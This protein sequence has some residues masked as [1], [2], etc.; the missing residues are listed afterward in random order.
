[1]VFK[2]SEIAEEIDEIK[3]E[4]VDVY[5]STDNSDLAKELKEKMNGLDSSDQI[6]MVF[7]GQ[8]TAGKSSIISALTS[9]GSIKIDSD[10]STDRVTDYPWNGLTLTDTPGLYTENPEHNALAVESIKNA[11]LLVYCITSDLF[12]PYTI[13]D[14]KKWAFR[15]GYSGKMFL[16]INKMSK[17]SGKY[18]E[19]VENYSETLNNSLSPYSLKDVTHSFVDAV[20]YKKGVKASDI[21]LI[22]YSHFEDFIKQLNQFVKDKGELG[23]LDTPIQ[24]MKDSIDQMII[25][26]S[27]DD[28]QIAYSKTLSRIE[29][30]VE[31]QRNQVNIEANNIVRRGLQPIVDRGYELSK[32]I[33][34]K[35]LKPEDNNVNEL[36]SECCEKINKELAKVCEESVARLNE[37]IEQVLQSETAQY[38]FNSICKT[39]E[40]KKRLFEKKEK[41]VTRIQFEQIDSIVKKV[42]GKV[43]N[44]VPIEEGTRKLFISASDVAGSN[45]HLMIK[46]IGTRI[47]YKFRP[48]EAANIT[49]NVT[50]CAKFL[51]PFV[52]AVGTAAE[53]KEVVD[54]QAEAA[55]RIQQQIECRS[56]FKDIADDLEKSY[57]EEIGKLLNIYSE[58]IQE[59]NRSM[60]N[61][62]RVIDSNNA[63][64]ARLESLR[65]QLVD[66]QSKIFV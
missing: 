57:H 45:L 52:V 49:K 32:E 30:K 23:R 56:Y 61:V 40:E 31:Q 36:V 22:E 42:T 17:E 65:G 47:G 19:L 29:K 18:P 20:D 51:G 63:V 25:R 60:A 64:S 1:M 28:S 26:I 12:T 3:E 53:I 16:V 14:F 6:R 33:G 10:I 2:A 58:L 38:F 62:Q 41:K 66:L 48:W 44:M 4:L 50:N 59:I 27:E 39:Y 34:I 35:D 11:D 55:K 37:E 5:Y 24:I 21:A 9:N 15:E 46:E 7:I 8:Y 43:L 13:E 54:E